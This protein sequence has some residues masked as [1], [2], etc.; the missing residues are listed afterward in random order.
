M[1]PVTRCA[2][3]LRS[4]CLNCVLARPGYPTE[5][6]EASPTHLA[7]ICRHLDGIPLAIELAAARLSALSPAE[8]DA[9]LDDRFTLL[10]DVR[11]DVPSRHQTLEAMVDWSYQLL[12]EAQRSLFLRLAVF[13][14]RFSLDAVEQVCGMAGE[15]TAGALAGLVD[16]SLVAVVPRPDG[17]S[18]YRML[19][20]I[21]QFAE[22]RLGSE[23]N[24]LRTRHAAYFAELAG[25]HAD[26]SVGDGEQMVRLSADYENLRA[27]LDFLLEGGTGENQL[28]G[29][30]MAVA[31]S[32]YWEESG[33]MIEGHGGSNEHSTLRRMHPR[34]SG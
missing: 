15:D 30:R 5:T 24:R 29:L 23:L 13:H 1:L 22:Q 16:R 12:P 28:A 8:L 6:I 34:T 25:P 4:R 33:A 32:P 19:G 9:R 31:L 14:G 27:A 20:T 17:W 10:R 3:S 18:R 2:G 11:R 21:C 7:S 26:P